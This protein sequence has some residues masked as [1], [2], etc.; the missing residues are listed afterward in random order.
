MQVCK[1]ASLDS[2]ILGI[3]AI[4]GFWDSGILGFWDSGI[5]GC[6]GGWVGGGAEFGIRNSELGIRNS[7]VTD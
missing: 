5:L 7:W 3:L 2:W 1:F 4:L 6:V